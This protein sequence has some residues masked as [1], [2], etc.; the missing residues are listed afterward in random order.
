MWV[1]VCYAA[2]VA[3][4][5]WVTPHPPY[6]SVRAILVHTALPSDSNT[7]SF[8][9]MYKHQLIEHTLPALSPEHVLLA[10][11]LFGQTPF[12]HPLRSHLFRFVRG[13]LWYYEF[14]RLPATVHR[15]CTPFWIFNAD[16][17]YGQL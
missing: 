2:K 8:I 16:H 11:I 10:L 6:R 5:M 1:Q 3:V 17:V 13:L 12:L 9:S 14:V 4:G 7:K 15:C